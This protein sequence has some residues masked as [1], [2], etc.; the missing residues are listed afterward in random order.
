MT[1]IPVLTGKHQMYGFDGKHL[2]YGFD[3]QIS[4]CRL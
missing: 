1:L 3:R 4:V 2:M